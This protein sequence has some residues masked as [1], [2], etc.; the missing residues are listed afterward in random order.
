MIASMA[1]CQAVVVVTT[2]MGPDMTHPRDHK[3]VF[4]WI[5]VCDLEDQATRLFV[6]RRHSLYQMVVGSEPYHRH[7][8]P[9]FVSTRS[10]MV[11]FN[12]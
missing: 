8:R 5:H 6:K 1:R 10:D 4:V 12:K 3:L 2:Q 11:V 9:N 7:Q